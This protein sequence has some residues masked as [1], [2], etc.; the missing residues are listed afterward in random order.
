MNILIIYYNWDFGNNRGTKRTIEDHL[1]SFKRYE[2]T[3]NYFY[4]NLD[5]FD[6]N[7]L[8]DEICHMYFDS[9]IFHYSFLTLRFKR[10]YQGFYMTIREKLKSLSGVKVLL[11][12]DEYIYTSDLWMLINDLDI[13]RVY[14]CLPDDIAVIY[15]EKEIGKT[16]DLFRPVLTG[17][18]DEGL[19]EQVNHQLE[20]RKKIRIIDVGYR[21]LKADYRFGYFG[22]QKSILHDEFHKVASEFPLLNHDVKLTYSAIVNNEPVVKNALIG[23]EW[24]GFLLDCRTSLGTLSGSSLLDAYGNIHNE[25]QA[26]MK[27]HNNIATYEEIEK[28][29]YQGRDGSVKSEVYG[30]RHF[31]YA[32]AKTCPVFLEGDYGTELEAG[33]HYIE[34]KRNYSNMRD[35]IKQV[36][37][38]EQCEKIALEYRNS[39]LNCE[40]YSY[41]T[42]AKYIIEDIRSLVDLQ[43]M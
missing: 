7:T 6:P 42:F 16:S 17:Y 5:M 27:E 19:L 15:P 9:V 25:V 39:M 34:I 36:L 30:P 23:D 22:E 43:S 32:M 26:Y 3:C 11:P 24:F 10:A 18:I 20:E 31:E 4:L 35:V 14:T 8:T 33:K 40:K 28:N 12:H 1:Y 37:D 41:R 38:I 21:A 2:K 13:K 29:C